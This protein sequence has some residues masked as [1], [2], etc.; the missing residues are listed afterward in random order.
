MGTSA[1]VYTGLDAYILH[2]LCKLFSRDVGTENTDN[3]PAATD[4]FRHGEVD[5]SYTPKYVIYSLT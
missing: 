5:P 2:T 1:G 3:R 4:L